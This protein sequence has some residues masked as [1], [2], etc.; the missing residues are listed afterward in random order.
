MQRYPHRR[1]NGKADFLLTVIN[2]ATGREIFPFHARMRR[3][4]VKIEKWGGGGDSRLR[5]QGADGARCVTTS[6]CR[7]AAARRGATCRFIAG[8]SGGHRPQGTAA[9][10]SSRGGATTAQLHERTSLTVGIQTPYS[11][12][13]ICIVLGLLR[14]LDWRSIQR[15]GSWQHGF[16][17][18]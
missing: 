12:Y 13:L 16:F 4:I 3:C 5:K 2:G 6:P 17:I 11:N 15:V 1:I 8:S 18:G 9:L 10:G 7:A 14:G